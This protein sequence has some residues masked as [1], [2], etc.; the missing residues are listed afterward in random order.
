MHIGP[1]DRVLVDHLFQKLPNEQC[2]RKIIKLIQSELVK[3]MPDTPFSLGNS[4]NSLP[5]SL[6]PLR[7]KQIIIVSV[8]SQGKKCR[9][10]MRNGIVRLN[11]KLILALGKPTT[12]PSNN[13][14]VKSN[15]DTIIESLQQRIL[16]TVSES[17]FLS[18]KEL[19]LL[20]S[21]SL[22][23]TMYVKPKSPGIWTELFF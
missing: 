4:R 10:K 15:S 6:S 9:L 14:N 5:S 17:T 12:P 16:R 7:E 22:R 13:E 20:S 23:N 19:S 2:R 21:H 8:D 11:E 1:M 3:R 18:F